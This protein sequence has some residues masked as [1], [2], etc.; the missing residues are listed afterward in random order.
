[1]WH[2]LYT[3]TNLSN[4]SYSVSTTRKVSTIHLPQVYVL[5]QTTGTLLQLRH[6]NTQST[7]DALN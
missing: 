4:I 5:N 2:V 1:M 3:I 6:E 7:S